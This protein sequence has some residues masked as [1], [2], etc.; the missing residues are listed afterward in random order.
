MKHLRCGIIGFGFIGPH[1]A[2]AIRRL[3]FVEVSAICTGHADEARQ[4]AARFHIPKAYATYEE[5]L[6]DSSIDVVDIVTPTYLHRRIAL[7]AIARGKHVIVDKPLAMTAAEAREMLEAGRAQGIVHAVTFNYRYNPVVQ[8][9]R[10]MIA[11]GDIGDV[12]L[13]HGR[14]F[15]EA[16]LRDTDFNWRLEPEQSGQAAL[17]GDAASHWF[18]LSWHLTGLPIASVFADLAT[19]IKTRKRPHGSN[20]VHPAA[21]GD[22]AEVDVRV[23]DIGSVLVRFRN[24][25]RGAFLLSLLS[26]GRKNDLRI[27]IHGSRGSL[28]WV[29]ERPEELW[30]GK[31]GEPNQVLM[32]DPGLLHPSARRYATLP[33]G[34]NEAW[35]DA[36]RNLMHNIFTFIAEGCDGRGADGVL[37]PTFEDGCRAAAV[38]DA[39]MKSH[40]AGGQWVDVEQ[41]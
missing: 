6:D 13:V 20:H 27:E 39:I 8:H 32:A 25:G 40:A 24:G 21:T 30:I 17:V 11:D 3:G 9:A 38:M 37:F 19:I 12:H 28:A 15:F 33:G 2:D 26:A 23:H 7:A 18:D 14:Y 10:A 4:K 1:H 41:P 5:L 29:Q 36:F 22:R 35:P 34:H 16:L 31:R